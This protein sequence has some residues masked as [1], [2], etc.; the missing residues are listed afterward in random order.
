MFLPVVIF[1]QSLLLRI[2]HFISDIN[3]CTTN[4][5]NAT[6]HC[7]DTIGN[8]TCACP[9]GF[10]ESGNKCSECADGLAGDGKTCYGM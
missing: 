7:T 10:S 6:Y 9:A 5:C 8:Y 4:P 1:Y 3:E 2:I